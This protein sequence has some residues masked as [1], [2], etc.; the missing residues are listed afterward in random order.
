MLWKW[1]YK[2]LLCEVDLII[3]YRAI[4]QTA[5][6]M[7]CLEL[8]S[9]THVTNLWKLLKKIGTETYKPFS[10]PITAA[11]LAYKKYLPGESIHE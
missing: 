5:N 7:T 9:V 1:S 2:K 8:A 4:E 10:S 6:H 11:M 3:K